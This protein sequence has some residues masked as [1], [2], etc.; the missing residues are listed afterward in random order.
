MKEEF[1]LYLWPMDISY[2]TIVTDNQNVEISKVTS[3][4]PFNI[5]QMLKK[6]NKLNE[7]DF[8]SFFIENI[9]LLVIILIG[10]ILNVTAKF[11]LLKLIKRKF[12][13]YNLLTTN[14]STLGSLSFKLGSIALAFS[15]FLF[16]NLNILTNLIKTEKVTVDTSEFIDSVSKLNRTT[17]T[18]IAWDTNKMNTFY[19]LFKKRKKNDALV[20]YDYGS[21]G[22]YISKLSIH[23]LDSYF[24]FMDTFFFVFLVHKVPINR[25]VDYIVFCKPT[26]YFE[27]LRTIFHRKKLDPKMKQILNR[28]QVIFVSVYK[29]F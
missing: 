19:R 20:V 8:S 23:D 27:I 14:E 17:K 12:S 9:R 26:I 1:D 28:R 11:V 2:S 21:F 22:N 7:S 13:L 24:Y 29:S 6:P 25:L 3:I 15:F 5:G 4:Y 16:F 10:F 18:L